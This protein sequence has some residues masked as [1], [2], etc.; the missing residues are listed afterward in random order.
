MSI[1]TNLERILAS[2]DEIK[3]AIIS[4]GVTVLESDKIDVY[5]DK[6]YQIQQGS[7]YT[8]SS[9]TITDDTEWRT[10]DNIVLSYVKADYS[11]FKNRIASLE[12]DIINLNSQIKEKMIRLMNFKQS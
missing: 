7:E 6:I 1:A 2:K 9:L 11:T 5:A 8:L 4:K 3:N 12:N 10:Q